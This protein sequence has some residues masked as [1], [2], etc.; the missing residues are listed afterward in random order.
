MYN[1][2]PAVK[3]II[4]I[5][6]LMF[7]ATVIC[8]NSAIIDL[9][10]YL[11]LH[12]FGSPA[13]KLYQIFTNFFMH[14]NFQHIAFNMF[15][16]FSIGMILEQA[17]GSKQFLNYY[18]ICG[19]GASIFH[20]LILAYSAHSTLGHLSISP[21]DIA[22]GFENFGGLAVGASGAL[23]GVFTAVAILYPNIEFMLMFI[24]IPIKAKYLFIFFVI[25]DIFLGGMNFSWDNIG[26]FAHLGGVLTGIIMI[27]Y[28]YKIKINFN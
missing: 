17:W 5:N 6:V 9:N 21:D 2:T 3:N 11:G 18:L 8:R 27:K 12:Y 13:F 19:L 20:L 22:M 7:G 25:L 1:I 10:Y 26:H 28:F 23:L 4:I 24:P 15:S 16:L 14:A